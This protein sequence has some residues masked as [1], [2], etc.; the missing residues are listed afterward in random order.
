MECPA[1]GLSVQGRASPCFSGRRGRG[2]N[3]RQCQHTAVLQQAGVYLPLL[4]CLGQRLVRR[5]RRGVRSNRDA[6]ALQHSDNGAMS[7]PDVP[8]IL[9]RRLCRPDGTVDCRHRCHHLSSPEPV[10]DAG[11]A[12]RTTAS[13]DS[14]YSDPLRSR[15]AWC[16]LDGYG[17]LETSSLLQEPSSD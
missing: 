2:R 14:T 9:H 7:R 13:P 15:E 10:G 5:N 16:L 6:E 4:R 12:R 3:I 1:P 11:C 8:V 17:R